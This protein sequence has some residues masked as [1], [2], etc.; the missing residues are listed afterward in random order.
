MKFI[1]GVGNPDK[2]YDRTRHNIGFSVVDALAVQGRSQKWVTDTKLKTILAKRPT[3]FLAKPQTYVNRTGESIRAIVKEHGLK[4]CDLLIVCD[5]VNIAF[6]KL[7]LRAS[8]SAGGHHGLESIIESLGSDEFA[9]LRIGVGNENMPEDLAVFVLGK[10]SAGEKKELGRV[11][12]KAV[13]VCEAWETKGFESARD[14]LSR[15]QSV[16]EKG[17][18]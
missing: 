4:P 1:V 15:L 10:F 5:D 16:K 17:E 9:R 12:E 3:N 14:C 6:G 18:E 13:L 2:K 8:G 11:I 7:R